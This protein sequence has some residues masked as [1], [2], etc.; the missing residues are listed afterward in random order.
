MNNLVFDEKWLAE[1]EKRTG[2][3]AKEYGQRPV[4]DKKESKP[5]Q[6]KYRAQK[7]AYAGRVY[8]SKREAERAAELKVLWQGHEI[9]GIAEQVEFLLPGG[10]KYRADFVILHKDGTWT[11]EDSKGYQ[12]KEYRIKKKLMAEQGWEIKE[13]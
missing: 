11:I 10:V 2:R 5:K 12:T 3:K 9:A 7:T 6:S 1:Y 13:V 4:Q 8:D